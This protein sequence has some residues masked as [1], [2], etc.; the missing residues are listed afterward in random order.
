MYSLV[1]IPL[2]AML[3]STYVAGDTAGVQVYHSV[4][5][6]NS[7][8]KHMTL[9]LRHDEYV[10]LT[11]VDGRSALYTSSEFD[12]AL[13][14]V[15]PRLDEVAVTT[16]A[17]AIEDAKQLLSFIALKYQPWVDITEDGI[18]IIQWRVEKGGIAL[19]FAGDNSVTVSERTAET[20]YVDSAND[21]DLSIKTGSVISASLRNLYS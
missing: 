17:L 14:D 11:G 19:L 12:K 1:T 15:K 18:A 20:N 16:A 21:Y 5:V 10:S 13:L 4:E 7:Y 9:E 8:G 6:I 2:T 3:F